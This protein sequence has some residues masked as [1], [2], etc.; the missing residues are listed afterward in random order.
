MNLRRCSRRRRCKRWAPSFPCCHMVLSISTT[1]RWPNFGDGEPE[2]PAPGDLPFVQYEGRQEI[3]SPPLT[4]RQKRGV[5][6]AVDEPGKETGAT[7]Q[8]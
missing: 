7:N 3:A 8:H 5:R 4:S 2:R 6:L 1:S